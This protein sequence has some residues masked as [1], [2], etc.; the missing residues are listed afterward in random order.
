MLTTKEAQKALEE[1]GINVAYSTIAYW[2]RTGKFA[3]AIQEQT[4]RGAVWYIPQKSV[5][6]FEQ[7]EM[8]R[9]KN[10]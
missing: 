1:R 10:K 8:G 3:D 6:N 2:V 4:P 9:P 5:A 7:P